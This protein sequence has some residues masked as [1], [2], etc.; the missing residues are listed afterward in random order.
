MSF[1]KTNKTVEKNHY[2]RKHEPH[3]FGHLSL[4]LYD[5]PPIDTLP[6][7]H[8]AVSWGH[9]V[10]LSKHVKFSYPIY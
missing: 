4:T 2:L 7:L 9:V 8:L 1:I 5:T 3:D 10:V 6:E